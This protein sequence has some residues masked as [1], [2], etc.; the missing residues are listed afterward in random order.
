MNVASNQTI[1]ENTKNGIVTM[2]TFYMTKTRWEET[3]NGDLDLALNLDIVLLH[4]VLK[5]DIER[6][7]R[8][9]SFDI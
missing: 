4:W 1:P 2:E 9:K 6:L 3:E 7:N 8:K 5:I